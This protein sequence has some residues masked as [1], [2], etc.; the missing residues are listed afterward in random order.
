VH[1]E[2]RAVQPFEQLG[3]GL[4]GEDDLRPEPADQL[5]EELRPDV[6]DRGH[7][8]RVHRYA[9]GQLGDARGRRRQRLPDEAVARDVQP[10]A[11]L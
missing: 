4:V 9:P 7:R 5:A 1:H 8:R 3:L 11:A 6:V 2:R 10:V